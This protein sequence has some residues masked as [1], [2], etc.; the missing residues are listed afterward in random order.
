MSSYGFQL[1]SD[2]GLL[3]VENEELVSNH[4]EYA[5]VK[6]TPVEVTEIYRRNKAFVNV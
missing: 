6:A 4:R 3:K 2:Q 1:D 5:E